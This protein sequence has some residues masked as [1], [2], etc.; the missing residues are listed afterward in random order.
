MADIGTNEMQGEYPQPQ[1]RATN[2]H[3]PIVAG[4]VTGRLRGD[5]L[6]VSGYAPQT[7]VVLLENTGRTQFTVQMRESPD[8]VSGPFSNIGP[9]VA[10]VPSG[11]KTVVI[12]P[13]RDFLEFKGTS[14]DGFLKAQL[15][16]Q[17]K[18]QQMAFDKSDPNYPARLTKKFPD[19]S[20]PPANL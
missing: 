16:S 11:Q 9:A 12:T 8:Y 4:F 2:Y 14:G 19:P 6:S 17:V 10:L 7:T 5:L 13:I 1:L 3:L 20:P 15:T 18:W